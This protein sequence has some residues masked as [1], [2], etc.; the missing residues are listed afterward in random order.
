MFFPRNHPLFTIALGSSAHERKGG[1]GQNQDKLYSHI[2]CGGE[3]R[4]GRWWLAGKGWRTD[5]LRHLAKESRVW[6]SSRVR[7]WVPGLGGLRSVGHV[8][9][10]DNRRG[11]NVNPS[12]LMS[13]A[14][15]PCH[16][17]ASGPALSSP[18]GGRSG[19]WADTGASGHWK[20]RTCSLGVWVLE[21][22]SYGLQVGRVPRIQEGT[23]GCDWQGGRRWVQAEHVLL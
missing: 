23:V 9:L 15:P 4:P 18:W 17:Y 11:G 6:A 7:L 19:S 3:G 20:S 1:S 13:A 21:E 16:C 14:A 10:Y 12:K 8:F 2:G 22:P 5:P